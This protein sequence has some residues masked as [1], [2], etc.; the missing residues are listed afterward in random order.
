MK[1]IY[2]YKIIV[3]LIKLKQMLSNWISIIS[4]FETVFYIK[5]F[6][7]FIKNICKIL[8]FEIFY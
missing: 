8:F 7:Y 3:N 1:E 5:P 6:Y 4:R 2:M